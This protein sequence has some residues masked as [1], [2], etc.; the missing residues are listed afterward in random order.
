MDVNTLNYY[1]D[2]LNRDTADFCVS[3]SPTAEIPD[4]NFRRALNA[5]LNAIREDVANLQYLIDN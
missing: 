5:Q 1:A 2:I 3:C 4:A